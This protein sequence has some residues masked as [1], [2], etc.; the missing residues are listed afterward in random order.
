[1]TKQEFT[2]RRPTVLSGWI[3]E[4]LP[5]STTGFRVYDI[6]WIILNWETKQFMLL[7][8]KVHGYQVNETQGEVFNFVHKVLTE[9]IKSWPDWKYKGFYSVIFENKTFEDGKCYF[10]NRNS[11]VEVTQEELKKLLSI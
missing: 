1:M 2:F 9:G 4:N 8:E 11:M 6:D 10:G 5:S 7:E 3:R